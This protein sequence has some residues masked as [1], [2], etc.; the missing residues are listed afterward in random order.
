VSARLRSPIAAAAVAALL[1]LGVRGAVIAQGP[2]LPP[3]GVFDLE[4]ARDLQAGRVREAVLRRFHPLEGALAA[5]VA[6]ILDREA[7]EACGLVVSALA[8]AL[9]AFF[10]ALAASE[11]VGEEAAPA[12]RTFAA[13]SAGLLVAAHPALAR[14]AA[15]VWSYSLSHAAVAFALWT[16]ARARAR[17]ASGRALDAG[18]GAGTAYLAR[19]DG[20]V[21][22]AGL[23]VASFLPRKG[24][25]KFLA[26]VALLL[27][28]LL[29]AAP[30]LIALRAATGEWRLTLKKDE[31]HLVGMRDLQAPPPP[32]RPDDDLGAILSRDEGREDPEETGLVASALYVL[33]RSSTT[34]HPLLLVLG[35]VGLA[36][37]W[38]RLPDSLGALGV[39]LAFVGAH[40]LLKA[41][42]RDFNGNHPGAEAVIFATWSALAL[43]PLARSRWARTVALGACALV[44]LAKTRDGRSVEKTRL[45]REVAAWLRAR[46]EPGRELVVAGRDARPLAFLAGARLVELP[47]G[48]AA[49]VASAARG[50]GARFLAVYVRT[51]GEPPRAVTSALDGARLPA[52]ERFTAQRPAESGSILYTWLVYDLSGEKR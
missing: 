29:L 6:T 12:A 43:A 8:G 16:S 5:G 38:R 52:P 51:H 34:I 41:N 23:F 15:T 7:D 11:L 28:F 3:D 39:L 22:L 44:L 48:D 36:L 13:L 49:A 33:R 30:Y 19:P 18:L 27:G 17:S 45:T 50:A 24:D 40:T 37:R 42:E 47:R 20:L 1:A 46:A 31:R 25:K 4:I 35:A 26:P 2:D 9:A 32:R 10:A 14:S 21:V